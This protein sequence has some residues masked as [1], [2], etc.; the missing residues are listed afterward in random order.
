[1]SVLK[2]LLQIVVALLYT[3]IYASI[4]FLITVIPVAWIMSLSWWQFLLVVSIAG[5]IIE[6][7][8]SGLNVLIMIPFVWVVNK[9]VVSLILCILSFIYNAI[10]FIIDCW[11]IEHEGVWSF[12]CLLIIS[13][14]ILRIFYFASIGCLSAYSESKNVYR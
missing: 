3:G 1:M 13:A 4:A 12:I 6:A 2:Y 8:I 9:N 7:I 5:G 10:Y 14:F 11:K